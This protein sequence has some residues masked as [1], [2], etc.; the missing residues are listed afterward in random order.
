M[1]QKLARQHQDQLF[2]FLKQDPSFNLF[3]IGD[4]EVFGFDV[5]FQD[6]WGD[7]DEKGNLRATLFRYY[8]T[9]SPY[10]PTLDYDRE[11][12]LHIL[13]TAPQIAIIQGKEEL[14]DHL[15]RDFPL[16]GANIRTLYFAELAPTRFDQTLT[17]RHEIKLATLGDIDR[18]IE[19]RMQISEFQT[20]PAQREQLQK[21]MEGNMGRTFYTEEN[22]IMTA[23]AS[24]TAENSASAMIVGVCTLPTHR[25]KGLASDCM[26]RLCRDLT[27]EGRTLCLFYDNP[28]AGS[29]YK[30][31]GFQDIGMWKMI[32]IL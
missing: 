22:G 26:I 23:A 9:Y 20:T 18:I 32:K 17:P 27:L 29:I 13:N 1:I 4:F 10:C 11:G 19:L 12:F 25:Q 30:R 28:K 5:D 8:N 2:T 21:I 16:E 15:T 31:L 3:A 14:V 6:I 24:T 7:F